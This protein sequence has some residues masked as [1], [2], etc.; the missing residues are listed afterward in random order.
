[1]YECAP[2]LEQ[3]IPRRQY[4]SIANTIVQLIRRRAS[5]VISE[6]QL[7]PAMGSQIKGCLGQF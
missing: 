4:Q 5:G 1:M 3:F 2:S 6:L 7:P